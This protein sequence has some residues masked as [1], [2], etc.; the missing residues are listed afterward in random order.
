MEKVLPERLRKQ[1]V[2]FG[3]AAQNI[4]SL[5]DENEPFAD[6]SFD[7]ETYTPEIEN[8]VNS[9]INSD[10]E[11]DRTNLVCF[12][13]DFERIQSE[14]QQSGNILDAVQVNSSNSETESNDSNNNS[15]NEYD[16]QLKVLEQFQML[17]TLYVSAQSSTTQILARIATIEESLMKNGTLISVQNSL[18][19]KQRAIDAFNQFT[20]INRLPIKTVDDFK[21]FEENLGKMPIEKAVSAIQYIYCFNY[22]IINSHILHYVLNALLN[23]MSTLIY[24]FY[25]RLRFYQTILELISVKLKETNQRF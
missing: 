13:V 1:P 19:E 7:D 11:D 17:K 21:A 6:N 18:D 15:K 3:E 12:D 10:Q 22:T 24:T 5:S 23:K 14:T 8:Q 2:R 20:E 9:S 25:H 4:S 16:F